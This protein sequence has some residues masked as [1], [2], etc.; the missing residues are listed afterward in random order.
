V[1]LDVRYRFENYVVGSANRLAVSAARAVAQA[2]GS[3]YNPLFIY[4]SSGLGKTHL[5]LAIGHLAR[6]LQPDLA[7][8]YTTVDEFVD[9]LT[10]AVSSG[11]MERFKQ[12]LQGMGMLLLDDVQFLA[13]RQETQSEML[14]LFNA[15]QRSGKQVVL[16]SD[17]PPAEIADLDERLI[18]RFSGGLVVDVGVP[19]YETR[20]AIL[21]TK[22]EERGASFEAGVLDEVARLSFDNVRELE[23]ALNRLIACQALGEMPVDVRSVRALLGAHAEPAMAAARQNGHHE[24]FAS[25]LS[26]LS[27]VVAQ[28]LETWR[29][30]VVEA[31]ASWR[32]RGYTTRM[33][34]RA[35]ES[36]AE[37]DVDALL[38]QYEASVARLGALAEEA[39]AVDA[40]LA[41]SDLFRDPER[42]PE[43]EL[44]VA[45]LVGGA[46]PPPGPSS[47]YSRAEFEVGPSN[48]LA[49]H[50][51]DTVIEEP[52]KKYNPIFV[53]GPAGVGK[54]HLLNALGNELIA[55]SGEAMIVACVNAQQFVDE[56]IA[57]LQEGTIE[58]WRARYRI[59]DVLIVDDVHLCAGKERTQEELFHIFNSLYAGGRQIIF[60][61]DRPPKAI[62]G[63]EERLRSRF[64]GGLVVEMQPP[65]HVLREKLFARY[66]SAAN[67]RPDRPLV[68]YLA[69][70]SVESVAEIAA[71]VERLVKAAEVV[72]VP[73]TASFARKEL[74]GSLG[75]PV[76]TRPLDGRAVDELFLDEEKIVWDWPDVAGRAI[77]DFR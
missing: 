72:G 15:L 44:M 49:V 10:G 69:S 32:E 11:T 8:E 64:E 40:H 60:A 21:R 55:M 1:D 68:D 73:L 42:I 57:A 56:L 25:F 61:A 75:A 46:D 39:A 53:H 47:E 52:G 9:E 12:R 7:I 41:S 50:A 76:A 26:D 23:G 59:I 27:E 31:M 74:E 35:L 18:T 66:L 5:L 28:H 36:E 67:Q 14:R 24:E 37:P 22:T 58:R 16:T 30:R 43:A 19:D 13:G 20:V 62:E 71:T 3:A 45:R 38:A 6:Q 54:T 29:V 63:L 51:A 33:L 2:P 65:D 34:E 17:R 48:Q 4:S 70:R 77:E